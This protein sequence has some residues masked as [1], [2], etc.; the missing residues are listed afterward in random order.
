[1]EQIK[2]NEIVKGFKGVVDFTFS[3][4][5]DIENGMSVD[6]ALDNPANVK[7]SVEAFRAECSSWFGIV[8][9][10]TSK[11]FDDDRL[12]LYVDYYGGSG[13]PQLASVGVYGDDLDKS[14]LKT[15]ISIVAGTEGYT[16][17]DTLVYVEL[18]ER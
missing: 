16:N 13:D 2:T 4:L 17:E 8:K 18:V 15:A 14:V 6:F 3:H 9:T 10:E 12:V 11:R 5:K 7:D 1:M